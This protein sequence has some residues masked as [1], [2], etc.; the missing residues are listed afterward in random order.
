MIFEDYNIPKSQYS[1]Q[2]LNC[3]ICSFI[4]DI[5]SIFLTIVA[6]ILY[7]FS[8]M[9]TTLP[10]VKCRRTVFKCNYQNISIGGLWQIFDLRVEAIL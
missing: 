1:V 2:T 6:I 4:T 9:A 7:S 10:V 5:R 8:I 3:Y